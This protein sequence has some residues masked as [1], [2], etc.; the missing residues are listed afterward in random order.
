MLWSM[1]YRLA[2]SSY[3]HWSGLL[4]ANLGASSGMTARL[5]A[6]AERVTVACGVRSGC[7]IHGVS[8]V[9]EAAPAA[10]VRGDGGVA[11]A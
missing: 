11:T 3:S 6:A 9:P 2:I 10:R 4:R 7:R 8:P 5:H 1:G